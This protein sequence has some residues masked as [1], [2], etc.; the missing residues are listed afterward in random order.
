MR[1]RR[2]S[3]SDTEIFQ[4][5]IRKVCFNLNVDF[6]HLLVMLNGDITRLKL[7]EPKR[8]GNKSKFVNDENVPDN[9][10]ENDSITTNRENGDQNVAEKTVKQNATKRTVDSNKNDVEPEGGERFENVD[11]VAKRRI[12]PAAD[13]RENDRVGNVTTTADNNDE[14]EYNGM[15]RK[16]TFDNND[17]N[18][19]AKEGN[20][21]PLTMMTVTM[22]TFRFKKA[23]KEGI[24]NHSITAKRIKG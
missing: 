8:K 7:V 14:G 5:E 11:N 4:H 6:D 17:T 1:A 10:E 23:L 22:A 3:N 9:S 16:R 2:S 13:Q 15:K 20:P 19:E 21:M 24:I 12:T 18:P